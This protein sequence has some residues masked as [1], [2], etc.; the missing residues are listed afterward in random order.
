[1]IE[2]LYKKNGNFWSLF[3]SAPKE[4]REAIYEHG[5]DVILQAYLNFGLDR[6]RNV[7]ALVEKYDREVERAK[8]NGTLTEHLR[9]EIHNSIAPEIMRLAIQP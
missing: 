6:A 9:Q 2:P 5:E 4:V 8:M 1:M 7:I 3:D